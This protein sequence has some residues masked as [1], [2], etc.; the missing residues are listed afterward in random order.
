[1]KYHIT[2][3]KRCQVTMAA[4]KERRRVDG[5]KDRLFHP[6]QQSRPASV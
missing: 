6:H 3:I 4:L 2:K 5:V 1:M